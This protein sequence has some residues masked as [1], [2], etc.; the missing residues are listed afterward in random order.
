MTG[1]TGRL[2]LYCL[3]QRLGCG[4]APSPP[5]E[6][7]AAGQD[8]AG[9]SSASCRARH[10]EGYRNREIIKRLYG[11]GECIVVIKTDVS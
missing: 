11:P 4:I 1:G 6:Q 5:A 9:Q 2:H 3:M 8:Q 7:T 10:R